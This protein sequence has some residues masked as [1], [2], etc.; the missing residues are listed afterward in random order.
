MGAKRSLVV[1]LAANLLLLL[2]SQRGALGAER[3]V[4]LKVPG[5]V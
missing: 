2:A 4:R 3:I 1:L 5:C